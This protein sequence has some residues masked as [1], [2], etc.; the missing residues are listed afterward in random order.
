MAEAGQIIKPD[1][2]AGSPFAE[3]EIDESADLDFYDKNR[4]GDNDAMYLARL[5]NFLWKAW[6]EL[7]DDAEIEIGKIR[8]WDEPDGSKRLQMLLRSDIKAHDKLPKE[9]DLEVANMNVNNTF[10]FT[11]QDLPSFAAKNKERA[12]AL[13]RGIP[14][15]LLRQQQKKM[16]APQQD[17][18]R[19]GAPYT[20]RAV[21][22]KTTI[23]GTIK[24]ELTCTPL[25]NAE[26]DYFFQNRAY[27]AQRIKNSVKVYN[28]LPPNGVTDEREWNS[29]IKTNEKPTKAKKMENK[30]AR[31]P[32]NQLMD[33]LAKCFSEHRYWS[34]RAFRSKI[35]QPE[36]FIRECLEQIAHLHRAGAFANHWSLKPEYQSMISKNNLPQP[37]NDAAAPRPDADMASEDEDEEDIKM[38]DVV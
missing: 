32:E 26:S 14:A 22:K 1:P 25:R 33:Q 10:I 11:E 37:V 36:A 21:P 23:A 6:S 4:H 34:I 28:R 31:W 3:D 19:K 12:D 18:G 15:H 20:R 35:P 29:F 27:K 13:A 24:H 17:R 7:D 2:E 38:E 16:E 9:Y 5:P 8:Q 30:T